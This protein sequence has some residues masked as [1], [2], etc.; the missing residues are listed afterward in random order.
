METLKK[1]APRRVKRRMKKMKKRM[2]KKMKM[3][4]NMKRKKRVAQMM[5][6]EAVM[7]QKDMTVD[8]KTKRKETVMRRGIGDIKRI[9]QKVRGEKVDSMNM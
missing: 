1:T 3:K 7:T 6:R 4:K 2:K 8:I 9:G 5:R